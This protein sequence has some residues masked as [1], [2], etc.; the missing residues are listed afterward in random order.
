MTTPATLRLALAAACAIVLGTAAAAF[1]QGETVQIETQVQLRNHAPAF[2]GRVKANNE[3]CVEDRKVKMFKQKRSGGHK[4]LGL[5]HADNDGKWAVP[6]D[7][8]TS[9]A[10]YAVAP[11]VVQG[12]AGTIYECVRDKSKV[13]AVD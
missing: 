9:G 8:L 11:K 12:T 3:N 6:F 13:I 1:A 2:H 5:D 10:Y 4:L 7:K